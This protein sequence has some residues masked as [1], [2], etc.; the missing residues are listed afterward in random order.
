MDRDVAIGA[1][2]DGIFQGLRRAPRVL[3][4]EASATENSWRAEGVVVS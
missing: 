1:L 2:A 3:H 4:P